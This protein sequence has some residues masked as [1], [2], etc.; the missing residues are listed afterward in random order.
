MNNAINYSEIGARIRRQ[1][2]HIG[3]TQEQLGEACG[4]STSFVGHIE[5]G[6]RKLSVESLYKM[7]AVLDISADYLLGKRM[8]QETTLPLEISSLLCGSDEKK[9][10]S[11]W[12]VVKILATHLDEL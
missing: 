9:R 8:L 2:E 7:T 6:S 10:Q 5:R 3:M 12:H 11:F 1:R 4:L